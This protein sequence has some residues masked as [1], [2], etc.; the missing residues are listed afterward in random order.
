MGPP[1]AFPLYHQKLASRE[2]GAGFAR[3]KSKR[4]ELRH[5]G[6]NLTTEGSSVRAD[7]L[8]AL[9][10]IKEIESNLTAKIEALKFIAGS[11]DDFPSNGVLKSWDVA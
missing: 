2:V 7:V 11:D 8:T 3:L 6:G 4:L 5:F 9:S 10:W 1:G